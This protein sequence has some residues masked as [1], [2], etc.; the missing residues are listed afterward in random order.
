MKKTL[1][2]LALAAM[3][4]VAHAA[5][6]VL[7]RMSHVTSAGSPK[8]LGAEKFK[9]LVEKNSNGEIRVE[10]YHAGTKFGDRDEMGALE[11][12]DIEML[13]PA[14][15]KLNVFYKNQADNPWV[16]LDMPFLFRSL[17]DV[18]AVEKAG[19]IEDM[20][21][22][23][24]VSYA[25]VVGFWDNGLTYLST[26]FK[27]SK[28][29]DME[30]LKMRIQPSPVLKASVESWGATPRVLAYGELGPGTFYGSVNS[31]FNP[32]SNVQGSNLMTSQKYLYR[33]N[34]A[35]LGYVLLFNRKWWDGLSPAHKNVISKALEETRP[36]QVAAARSENER[37]EER[38][39]N[40][41]SMR[42]VDMEPALLERMKKESERVVKV[43]SPSQKDY[44]DKI[45]AAAGKS[46]KSSDK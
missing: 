35:Y 33:T 2:A 7:L 6:P 44:Y 23:L 5:E 18:S 27:I 16:V 8:G 41:G 14:A 11:K 10:V 45:K 17:G 30:G 36:F 42:V 13:A 43:L 20:N 39:Q 19:I 31:S 3:A 9:S 12:G 28:W 24:K 37:A 22:T 25:S 34:N 21:K 4:V 29:E 32:P 15:S 40:T 38:I 1:L 26:P 46:A